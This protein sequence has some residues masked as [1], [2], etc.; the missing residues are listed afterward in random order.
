[1]NDVQLSRELNYYYT[2]IEVTDASALDEPN[3]SKN[4]PGVVTINK[5][6]IEFLTKSGNVLGQLRRGTLGSSIGQ[7]YPVGTPV[8]SAGVDD[9]IPYIDSQEKEE[10]VSDGSTLLIG[11]LSFV[12]TKSTRSSFTRKTIP[13][14]FGACDQVEI[15]VAG[16]RLRKDQLSVYNESLGSV[17]PSA[18]EILEAEFSVDGATPYIRLTK[19]ATEGTRILIIRKVGRLWY[20]RAET[21]ASKGITL[22]DNNTAIARFIDQKPTE[23]P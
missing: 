21:T 20:E 11:P 1:M 10:F 19:P 5:E 9:I 7:T 8:I 15:F 3:M 23:L 2:T 6:R 14:D 18:D 13:E 22:L 4:I 17:S 16:T 12:P